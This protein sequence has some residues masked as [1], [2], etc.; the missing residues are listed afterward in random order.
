M[1]QTL[2][3]NLQVINCY[4]CTVNLCNIVHSHNIDNPSIAYGVLMH[5]VRGI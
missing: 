4:I 1:T 3:L 2:Y 5:N